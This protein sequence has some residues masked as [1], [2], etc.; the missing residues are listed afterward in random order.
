M[1]GRIGQTMRTAQAE[2]LKGSPTATYW[3]QRRA[4]DRE[5]KEALEATTIDGVTLT[6]ATLSSPTIA[7]PTITSPMITG[8]T[9]TSPT[10]SGASLTGATTAVAPIV[11]TTAGA[12]LLD[13]DG[14]AF[15][16]MDWRNAN[17]L[18]FSFVVGWVNGAAAGSSI[19]RRLMAGI[20]LFV[21]QT[22]SKVV[23]YVHG[24]A[25]IVITVQV[26]VRTTAGVI[27]SLASTTSALSGTDQTLTLTFTSQ[28][29][30]GAAGSHYLDVDM[31]PNAG[32]TLRM[33]SAEVYV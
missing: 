7:T 17:G 32:Q 13:M 1:T 28:T 11:I 9:L 14:A 30:G 24:D 3:D 4:W 2:V 6:H 18:V 19:S 15:N 26:V 33:Y 23:F 16:C 31:P 29:I 22:F 8:G 21:G 5:V 27:T 10:I 20:P 25:A 12:K